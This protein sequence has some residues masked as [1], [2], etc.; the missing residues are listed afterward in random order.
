LEAVLADPSV[1][2]AV[3]RTKWD[4]SYIVF[5]EAQQAIERHMVLI[6]QIGDFLIY[7]RPGA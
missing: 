7:Q 1:T 5:P 4:Y 6:E 3:V 2:Y